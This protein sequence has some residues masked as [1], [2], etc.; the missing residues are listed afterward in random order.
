[1]AKIDTLHSQIVSLI[2]TDVTAFNQGFNEFPKTVIDE[3]LPAYAVYYSGHENEISSGATNKRTYYFTI[4]IIYDK[5]NIDTSQTV[6]SDLVSLVIDSL[7]DSADHRLNGN[8]DYTLPTTC[9]R[10]P[11][12]EISGK[13]YLGYRITLP[14][15]VNETV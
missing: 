13:Y 3:K 10:I 1:M 11:S 12:L 5:E 2:S 9:E 4:D 15:V 8:C 14:V 6:T 7:E